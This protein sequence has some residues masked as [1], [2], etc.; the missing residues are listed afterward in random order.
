[1]ERQKGED[2]VLISHFQYNYLN[3]HRISVN[4]E[5]EKPHKKSSSFLLQVDG[6]DLNINQADIE[7]FM[8]NGKKG[9]DRILILKIEY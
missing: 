3:F 1:M 2:R 5:I 8:W 9:E 7:M 4:C 6:E